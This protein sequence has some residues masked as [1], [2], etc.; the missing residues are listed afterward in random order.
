MQEAEGLGGEGNMA[1]VLR[2]CREMGG[3]RW[4]AEEGRDWSR[5]A[6][7]VFFWEAD[8]AGISGDT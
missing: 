6:C 4:L 2:T 8:V 3:K 5:A 1:A 7:G